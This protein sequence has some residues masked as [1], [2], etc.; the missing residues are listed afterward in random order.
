[1][2]CS[3]QGCPTGAYVLVDGLCMFVWCGLVVMI[4]HERGW[5][6][7]LRALW[8]Y[9]P[10]AMQAEMLREVALLHSHRKAA[11]RVGT[12][13]DDL[14]RSCEQLARALYGQPT[15][16]DW[17]AANESYESNFKRMMEDFK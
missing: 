2:Y 9:D 16:A 5:W 12:S 10:V 8:N 3:A 11:R 13:I 7:H 17:A 4:G 15:G 1:M 6:K 14:T